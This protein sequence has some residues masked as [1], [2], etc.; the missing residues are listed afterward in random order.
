MRVYKSTSQ[1]NNKH[2]KF[3]IKLRKNLFSGNPDSKKT[4]P[5]LQGFCAAQKLFQKP[6]PIMQF[7]FAPSSFSNL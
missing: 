3:H 6:M 1:I 2:A 7:V 5:L 4:V